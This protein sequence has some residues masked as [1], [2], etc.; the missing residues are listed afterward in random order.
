MLPFSHLCSDYPLNL[1]LFEV[2]YAR[3]LK[4]A[5][6]AELPSARAI[7]VS[8]IGSNWWILSRALVDRAFDAQHYSGTN[9]RHVHSVEPRIC[10]GSHT[11]FRSSACAS[12][13]SESTCGL[14]HVRALVRE[15][16]LN[17]AEQL[18]H[19]V[20]HWCAS[21]RGNSAL[22]SYALTPSLLSP[23]SALYEVVSVYILSTSGRHSPINTVLCPA[24]QMRNSTEGVHFGSVA[25]CRACSWIAEQVR[26]TQLRSTQGGAHDVSK[27]RSSNF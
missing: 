1:T 8:L 21:A 3:A 20:E 11:N 4:Q 24:F 15:F 25:I 14:T 13:A 19:L 23:N 2:P 9:G 27:Q 6:R 12:S 18:A 17:I 5:Y 10:T 22:Y 16:R 26:S 7:P